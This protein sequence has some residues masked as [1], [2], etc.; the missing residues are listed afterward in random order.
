MPRFILLPI[1][2]AAIASLSGELG[3]AAPNINDT[4]LLSQPAL[5]AE[6][7]AFIYAD[8]LWVAGS[9]ARMCGGLPANSMRSP[10]PPSRPMG[11]LLLLAA[12]AR[13]YRCLRGSNDGR[14]LSA[15][16]LAPGDGDRSR[17]HARRQGGALRF[18]ARFVYAPLHARFTVP[19]EGGMPTRLSIPHASQARYS[20]DG[21]QI[22]YTPLGDCSVQ[23][24]HYRGGAHSRI[25]IYH[26]DDQHVDVLPQGDERRNDL[27]PNW[28]GGTIYF[29]S[30]R[31]GE[32]NLFAYDTKAKTV[33]S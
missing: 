1:L 14:T 25:W 32:Y 26:C 18:A 15:V 3:S 8:S 10:I 11:A 12:N 33:V 6:H 30:D 21:Q 28:I 31:N 9:T 16:D 13:E 4:R 2:F 7:V 5:T 19:V 22:A 27:D 20:P 29:R 23:W 17:L 24:K